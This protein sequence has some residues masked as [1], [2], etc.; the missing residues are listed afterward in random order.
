ME[1]KP[2]CECCEPNVFRR[3][4]RIILRTERMYQTV[5]DSRM[6]ALSIHRSQHSILQEI[7]AEEYRNP[8]KALSQKDIAERFGISAAAVAMSLKKMEAEGYIMRSMSAADNR[9]NE[10]SLTD[11]GRETL[12][13]SASIAE[14]LESVVY[15]GLTK[16]EVDAFLNVIYKMQEN[17]MALPELNGKPIKP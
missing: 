2:K 5:L 7:G 15:H 9:Y 6:T 10:L 3:A 8:G 12:A 4:I 16:E 11:K 17:L 13:K 14:E 1:K